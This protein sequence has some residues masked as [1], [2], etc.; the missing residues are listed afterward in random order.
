MPGACE[1]PIAALKAAESRKYH[2]LVCLGAILRGETPHFDYVANEAAKGIAH[3]GLSTG[4]PTI[5]GVITT[6]TLNRPLTALAQRQG[7]KGQKL[8]CRQ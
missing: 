3:V 1:I 4:V 5:Y 6:E 8:L 2:A 7:I